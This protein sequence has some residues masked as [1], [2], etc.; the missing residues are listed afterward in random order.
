MPDHR[1][2]RPVTSYL[3]PTLITALAMAG[4][5]G[6]DATGSIAGNTEARAQ[7]L[8]DEII[9]IDTEID[10]RFDLYDSPDRD[11][12]QPSDMQFD[13][14][15]M[16]R[17]GMDAAV[18]VVYAN[19][20]LRTAEG[21]ARTFEAARKKLSA[22]ERMAAENADRIE[23]ARSADDVERIVAD[24]KRAALIGMVNGNALGPELEELDRY[25]EA[26]L[27]YIAFTH[28]GHNQ[29]SDSARPS[30][31]NGDGATEH[32]GLSPLGR[33][34]IVEMNRRGI[35]V[36][37]SQISADALL[38]AAS[39]SR[40]PV[41]ASHS[42]VHALV[43]TARNITDEG[44]LAI[45]AT[46][47]VIHIVAFRSYIIDTYDELQAGIAAVREEFGLAPTDTLDDLPEDQRQAFLAAY[48]GVVKSLPLPS[49]GQYVDH[50]DYAVELLG[51]DHVGISSDFEH[52]GGIDGWQ[53]PSE[54]ASI[55][56]ELLR[57]GYSDKDIAKIMGGNFL[58]VMR[59]AQ[60][61]GARLSAS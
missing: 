25:A 28:V 42:S 59:E 54:T 17:G 58:R 45:K 47:G 12:G 29:L 22:I 46:G 24:G 56:R 55:T 15:K 35:L 23:I 60:A 1:K 36:D 53:D 26:G 33:E 9:V 10:V 57:R 6:E 7:Q 8:H 5:G 52:G 31:A 4:C 40:A 2:P 49:V 37:V 19:Q 20:E 44:M 18:F 13:L 48:G 34:L 51:I 50:I 3:L 43:P 32:G 21:Y 38:E 39:L 61:T 27:V 14:D 16:E 30:E 11:P 41:I